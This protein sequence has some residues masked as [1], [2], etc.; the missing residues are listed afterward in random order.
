MILVTVYSVEITES[1][2]SVEWAQFPLMKNRVTTYTIEEV[3]EWISLTK[4]EGK[5]VMPEFL[6]EEYRGLI[7]DMI[8]DFHESQTSAPFQQE[9][10]FLSAQLESA[11]KNIRRLGKIID[12]LQ[13][14]ILNQNRVPKT[15]KHHE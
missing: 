6:L 8:C 13:R 3:I 5:G 9:I 12:A 14:R 15:K 2:V 7:I 1:N 4:D 11:Y 10:D